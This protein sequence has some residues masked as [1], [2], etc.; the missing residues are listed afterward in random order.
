MRLAASRR[1]VLV[2]L[3]AAPFA[4][5]LR[6]AAPLSVVATT[7]MIADV[8]RRVGGERVAVA[9]LMGPGVD[10]HG[11]RQTRSD[12]ALLARAD[13]I[14]WHGLRLEAQLQRLFAELAARKPVVAV[15]EALDPALLLADADYPDQPDPHVWMDPALWAQVVDAV[16]AALAAADPAGADV[17]AAN[18]A[19]YA[20]EIAALGAYATG[21]LA[22]V[23]EPTRVLVTAHDAFG[24]FGR[25]YG[26]EVEGVQ[27]IS[28]AAEAGLRRI[29]E[30]VALLV[31]RR[32][33]AVFVESS[34]SE[35]NVRALIE[36]AAAR[37]WTVRIG[38]ALFS[39]AMGPEGTYEGTWL[40][41]IDHNVTAIAR[42]L[43]GAAP[44]RGMRG[45][46]AGPA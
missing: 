17:F 46:L 16:R 11:Y 3:L 41:M 20:A 2:G 8:A 19:D 22:T 5:S 18:A 24:Y 37:G 9:G 15:A 29:E 39:D 32:I 26:F 33:P 1:A 23:P 30:L 14:L 45:L 12:V 27:G 42:A 44:E 6:A 38:A 34:V 36:G 13:L 10:P 35:R 28:T 25:A 31:D 40:G 7:G 21:V 43:G 4:T